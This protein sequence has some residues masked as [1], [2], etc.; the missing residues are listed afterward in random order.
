MTKHD[1]ENICIA[2]YQYE[3]PDERIAKHPL[4]Q[5]DGCKLLVVN[6]DNSVYDRIF[7][8]LPLLLD[9]GTVLIYNDSKVINARLRFRKGEKMD[10]AT[11]EVFCLEPHRPAEYVSNFESRGV[12]EWRCFV[13]NSKRWKSGTELK[14]IVNV[15]QTQVVL[16]AQ[17]VWHDDAG[18][19]VRF[20]WDNEGV[21]FSQII[22][23]AG[24][25]PIPPYLNRK[26]ESSDTV[27]YQT[28]Y[29]RMEGSVAAPTAG[30]HF[31]NDTLHALDSQGVKRHSVTLHVG[32]GTFQPVTGQTI[33]EHSMHLEFFSVERGLIEKLI[34]WKSDGPNRKR[35]LAVGTTSVRTLESLYYAGCLIKQG[36]WTGNVPQWYPYSEDVPEIS[37]TDSLQAVM[38]SMEG[39]L[40]YGE[41][42]LLIAPGF[43]FRIVDRMITNFHQPGSTLLLLISAFLGR[44]TGNYDI[45]R[46]IYKHALSSGYRFLSYGDACLL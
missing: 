33:A 27:D 16:R 36:K 38:D 7:Y 3:L 19:T 2:N 44:N 29:S 18:S 11:I 22:E 15:D 20:M 14:M 8:D 45:W 35:V 31:T 41:T 37:L 46:D 17:R 25:I 23:A 30:L 34:E 42:Q 24:E 26:S 28:V 40:F 4:E 21:T 10:G 43:R 6:T 32:A 9:A 5:R 13:G 12:C 39:N 1:I